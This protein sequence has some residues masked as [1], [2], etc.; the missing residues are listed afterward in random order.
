MSPQ[1]ENGGGGIAFGHQWTGSIRVL[2]FWEQSNGQKN[3]R[4]PEE[5]SLSY[6]VCGVSRLMAQV[7]VGRRRGALQKGLL[8]R[9]WV[10]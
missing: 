8:E 9:R 10:G 4:H 1:A 6:S 2:F 5:A 7:P 3:M